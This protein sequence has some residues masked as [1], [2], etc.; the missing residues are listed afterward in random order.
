M[1][2]FIAMEG[3]GYNRGKCIIKKHNLLSRR[4]NMSEV[5]IIVISGIHLK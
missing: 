2:L 4:K 1:F 5:K 3:F